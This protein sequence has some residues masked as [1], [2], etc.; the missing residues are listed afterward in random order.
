M[1]KTNV[2]GLVRKRPSADCSR[3][4]QSVLS[5]S[6]RPEHHRSAPNAASKIDMRVS[7]M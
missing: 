6:S 5:C 4:A 3:T 2:V 1:R 7:E